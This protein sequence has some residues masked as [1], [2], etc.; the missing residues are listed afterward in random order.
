M[1]T[2]SERKALLFLAA[3]ISLGAGVRIVRA[4]SREPA[5]D[6]ASSS[7]LNDQLRRVDSARAATGTGRTKRG[8]AKKPAR[9]KKPPLVDVDTASAELLETLNGIG[10]MLAEKIVAHRDSF[11]AFG[12]IEGLQRVRGVG[13]ALAARLAPHVTFSRLPRPQNAVIAPPPG[14]R[15][16]P[17]RARSDRGFP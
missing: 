16:A 4:V 13:P 12:S 1:P 17:K 2:P 7:A 3:V 15:K 11:G 8:A 10:P 6:P 14:R 9:P 5:A